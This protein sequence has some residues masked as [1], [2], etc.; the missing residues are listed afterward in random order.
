LRGAGFEIS[1][2]VIGRHAPVSGVRVIVDDIPADFQS[3]D[4]RRPDVASDYAG[5]PRAESS[6]FSVWAPI[7]PRQQSVLTLEA[8]LANGQLVT[9]ARFEVEVQEHLP[10]RV[11]GARSVEAP[12]FV[13]VGTQRGGTTSLYAYLSSHPQVA[14]AAMKETH[15]LT[16]RFTRGL[17][18]YLGLFPATLP[19]G[20]ITG[21]ATPY[22]LFHPLAAQRLRTVAPDSKVIVLLRNPIERA[23]SQYAMERARGDERLD[24]ADALGAEPTRLSGEEDRLIA[25]PTYISRA[26]KH[27]SYVA[28]GEYLPQ[29]R[30]WREALPSEHLLTL[31]SEDLY[32]RPAETFTRV[33]SFLGIDS[34]VDVPFTAHNRS[35][36][37]PM[38][39]ALRWRL[40]EHFAPHNLQL[41]A[42]LD[43]EPGW[44]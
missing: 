39:P 5:F 32:E 44:L 19:P 26:H 24:F 15:F 42:H 36:A 17:D 43:W 12:N 40:A 23:Y 3:L 21:E 18:W 2:W 29:V 6:G 38:D 34:E 10:K 14:P 30:R 28:R 8:Q 4:V 20:V 25:D 13:I 22:A 37:P 7:A 16:D 11:S 9:L 41:A 27:Y 31:R 33:T 1:G 35:G